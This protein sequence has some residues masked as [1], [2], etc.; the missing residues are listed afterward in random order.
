VVEKAEKT[1]RFDEFWKVFP[2]K[3][4]KPSAIK[5]WQKAVRK[6]DPGKIIAAARVYAGTEGVQ[7]GFIKF[8]QGWLNEER[9]NDPDL[10]PPSVGAPVQ[11]WVP[12]GVVR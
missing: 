8:P 11:R 2:K 12:G 10:Q 9:F 4:G 5:A 3:A 6:T 7:R 1:D